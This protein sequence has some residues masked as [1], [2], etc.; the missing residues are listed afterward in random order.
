[1]KLF[2][3]LDAQ[4][5]VIVQ[6]IEHKIIYEPKIFR[7]HRAKE[8]EE[9]SWKKL[10]NEKWIVFMDCKSNKIKKRKVAI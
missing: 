8:V 1:L 4:I 2:P 5:K 6:K 10:K 7:P 9:W 3:Q